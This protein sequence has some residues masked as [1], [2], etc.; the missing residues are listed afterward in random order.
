M[1]SSEKINFL[2]ASVETFAKNN[3]MNDQ[4]RKRLKRLVHRPIVSLRKGESFD[5]FRFWKELDDMLIKT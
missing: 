2:L 4:Q 1:K 5:E 3:N